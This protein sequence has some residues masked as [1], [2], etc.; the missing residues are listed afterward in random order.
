MGTKPLFMPLMVV[1]I[2]F[3]AI[4]TVMQS[5]PLLV[6]VCRILGRRCRG[7]E[8]SRKNQRAFCAAIKQNSVC[9]SSGSLHRNSSVLLTIK[10][11]EVQET[12]MVLEHQPAGLCCYIERNMLW[13]SSRWTAV[14]T[15]YTTE[16]CSSTTDKDGS[17]Q[18]G[19]PTGGRARRAQVW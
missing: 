19:S 18:K 6:V 13:T 3:L 10:K 16:R 8:R 12:S 17:H 15:P 7:V 2:F 1:A 5:L 9:H 14:L 11:I 4:S